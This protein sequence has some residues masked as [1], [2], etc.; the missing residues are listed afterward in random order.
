MKNKLYFLVLLSFLNIY[1]NFA[2]VTTS[3]TD[4]TLNS[5]TVISNCGLIDLQTN[6][7]N[8]LIINFKLVK[9]SAQAI[10]DSQLK[11]LLK[12][13][14]SSYGTEKGV[15][16]TVLSGWWSNNN[17]EFI[18][19][20]SC[21]ISENEIK[22]TGSSIV[23]E[24]ISNSGVKSRSCEYP[25]KKTPVPSFS[26]STTSLSLACGDTNAK[27]F[28]VTPTNIP[29]GATVTYS[30]NYSG[31]SGTATSNMNSVSLS[32]ISNSSL[33]SNIY[34]TPYINGVMKPTMTCVVTRSP[35][36]VLNTKI[37]D[38]T[39][40]TVGTSQT[41]YLPAVPDLYGSNISWSTTNPSVAIVNSSTNTQAVIKSLTSGTFKIKATVT[42]GCGQ[43]VEIISNNINVGLGST[44]PIMANFPN[45]YSNSASPCVINDPAHNSGYVSAFL[46]LE[47]PT[48]ESNPT[49]SD[50]EWENISG[51]FAFSG[52][53]TNGNMAYGEY[54]EMNFL[55]N[56]IPN[57]IEYRCRV[58]NSC[59]WSNW[60]NFIMTFSDGVPLV[61]TPPVTPSEYY[62]ISPN[63]ASATVNITLKNPSIFPS[64]SS[65][66][67]SIFTTSGSLVMPE[68]FI[69]SS[70]GGSLYIGNLP[71]HTYYLLKIRYNT[72][73]E[74]KLLMKN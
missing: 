32:P 47:S 13:D 1:S 69:N 46:K 49:Y 22:T 2:Q 48:M 60:K 38:G 31:W 42:N 67:V 9:P 3:I 21:N 54:I 10:G 17:T 20:I 23:L 50:W 34:V 39:I 66:Y 71:S 44:P 28:T 53:H 19:T 27:T 51:R 70:A 45:C 64:T 41:Y 4:V 24:F 65:L 63:P 5:Q 35:F 15:P 59:G 61:V 43:I 52:T 58:R 68:T 37:S 12:Y 36:T 26:L 72:A 57:Q 6:S 29:S 7:N 16:A 33:P 56:I 18:S 30:W 55:N 8:S 62:N 25:L 14:S 73:S 11:I 74:T 40:C